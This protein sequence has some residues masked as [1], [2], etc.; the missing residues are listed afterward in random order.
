MG[1]LWRFWAGSVSGVV[2]ADND[3]EAME[4]VEHY[5]TG[6]FSDGDCQGLTVW[7]CIKDDDYDSRFPDVLAVSY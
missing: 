5:M 1:N 2:I 3:T 7:P 4:K 6:H